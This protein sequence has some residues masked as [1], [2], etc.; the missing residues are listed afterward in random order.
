MNYLDGLREEWRVAAAEVAELSSQAATVRLELET[1]EA[2]RD[3]LEAALAAYEAL[4]RSGEVGPAAIGEAMEARRRLAGLEPRI[5][6]LQAL[7]D[8]L[9]RARARPAE[10]RNSARLAWF[11]GRR[12]QLLREIGEAAARDKTIAALLVELLAVEGVASGSGVR[13]PQCDADRVERSF[14][15]PL[16]PVLKAAAKRAEALRAELAQEG[17]A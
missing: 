11:N 9:R 7:A 2:E 16:R 10:A 4:L 8:D 6:E 14:K 17:L 1:L 13:R 5:A 15:I 12:E 3:R